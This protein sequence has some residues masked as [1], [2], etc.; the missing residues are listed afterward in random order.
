MSGNLLDEGFSCFRHDLIGIFSTTIN[1]LSRT[2]GLSF[3]VSKIQWNSTENDKPCNDD[4]ESV[5]P[6]IQTKV[7]QY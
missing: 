5:M 4:E 1:E 7:T 6:E 2:P 3:E